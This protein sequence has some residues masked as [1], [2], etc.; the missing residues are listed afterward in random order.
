MVY[1]VNIWNQNLNAT[2]SG[3]EFDLNCHQVLRDLIKKRKLTYHNL[4][5]VICAKTNCTDTFPSKHIHH[6]ASGEDHQCLRSGHYKKTMVLENIGS[7]FDMACHQ[8]KPFSSD[9]HNLTYHKLKKH[10]CEQNKCIYIF[11]TGH[12]TYKRPK[13]TYHKLK[14]TL[15]S[16]NNEN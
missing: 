1:L 10:I 13:I 15:H 14:Q 3:D 8:A 11:P 5:K 16:T 12:G 2:N 7:N 6:M 9:R 4:K